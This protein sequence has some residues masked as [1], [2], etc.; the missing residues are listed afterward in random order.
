MVWSVASSG[1]PCCV[2]CPRSPAHSAQLL[3][4]SSA[5]VVLSRFL[6]MKPKFCGHPRLGFW[7]AP[8]RMAAAL[9]GG[10][11]WGGGEGCVSCGTHSGPLLSPSAI[12]GLVGHHLHL[13]LRGGRCRGH[14][15]R[16]CWHRQAEERDQTGEGGRC[17]LLLCS[18][19]GTSGSG[20]SRIDGRVDRAHSWASE[21]A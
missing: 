20:T 13:H 14:Q 18:F 9:R 19:V 15:T 17:R 21:R 6:R 3:H 1:V 5:G 12:G 8:A 10:A 7:S 4:H 2:E 16:A 11:G